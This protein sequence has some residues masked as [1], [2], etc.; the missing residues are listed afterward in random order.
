MS[1]VNSLSLG[2]GGDGPE[3]VYSG[4]HACIV[5]KGSEIGGWRDNSVK[6]IM[7]MGDARPLD[8][9]PITGY[10]KSDVVRWANELKTTEDDEGVDIDWKLKSAGKTASS[11]KA[12]ASVSADDGGTSGGISIYPVVT[13]SSLTSYFSEIAEETGG[14]VV[15][16]SSYASVA[17]AVKEVIEQSVA[18]NGFEF[19]TVTVNETAGSVTVR[20]FGGSESDMASIGYQVVSGSAVSGVDFTASSDEQRLSWAEGE[21]SYKEVVIP[22]AEDSVSS[23]DKFFSIVLCNPVNMG[24]GGINVCRVNLKNVHSSETTPVGDVYLQ[25]LSRQSEM[26]TVSGSGY[27][28]IGDPATLTASANDG[29]VFTSWEN[30]DTA[31]VRAITVAEAYED[32]V[33]GVATYVASFCSLDDLPLPTIASPSVVTSVV[34]ET[35][36]WRLDYYSISEASVTCDGLP[37]GLSF[38]DDIVSGEA[39]QVGKS[40]VIFTVTNAKGVVSKE[41]EFVVVLNSYTRTLGSNGDETSFS[42]PTKTTTYNVYF[43]N[44]N[45]FLAGTM[46]IKVNKAKAKGGGCAT[47][48]T[49]QA[50]GGKKQTIK[51]TISTADGSGQGALSGLSFSAQGVT[52]TLN[53]YRVEGAIDTA[54][55]KD[56]NDISVLNGFKGK[57]YALALLPDKVTG[58]NAA[59]VNGVAG[60]SVAFAAKG[61][62]K[63]TG[64]LPDGTKVSVSSQLIVGSEWCCLPVIYSKKSSLAFMLWFDRAGNFDSVS[65]MT[66]WKGNG[67]EV[68]WDGNIE[69]MKVGNLS[70]PSR[71]NLVETPADIKGAEVV[72]AL[73]PQDV[74]VT[75]NGTKWDVPKADKVK[76]DSSGQVSSGANPSA[77]KLSYT[78]K[79]GMFKGSFSF[80]TVGKGRLNKNKATIT[81]VVIN[82]VGYGTAAVKGVGCW[83]VKIE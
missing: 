7:I 15:S 65:G 67:F 3:T 35:V 54:K 70:G 57:T 42:P 52:G 63:V 6:T 43:V 81:G 45:G 5:G 9:E 39:K 11:V 34:G 47:T 83:P 14:K 20:V 10:T 21:R 4:I 29:Y 13:S 78:A 62:T 56:A 75:P 24:L 50:L 19:E 33:D 73:L 41:I 36:W 25:C 71:F 61:K 48:V 82:G 37:S 18:A 77:L 80:Y 49:I 28:N 53:G 31:R 68:E 12:L 46:S 59:M 22:I 17:D 58:V 72:K 40:K 69:V 8:P 23:L 79:T 44:D 26:G 74:P 51:G 76:L 32:A 66:S 2:D 55:S 60:F 1:A 30:G 64:N 27:Y 16:A 38:S